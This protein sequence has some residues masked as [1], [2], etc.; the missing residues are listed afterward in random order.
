MHGKGLLSDFSL[1]VYLLFL[2]TTFSK[3]IARSLPFVWLF[4]VLGETDVAD[5]PL[6]MAIISL[7]TIIYGNN[8][9]C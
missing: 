5:S 7:C 9:D 4:I 3:S 8:Q 2:S 1:L 6:E